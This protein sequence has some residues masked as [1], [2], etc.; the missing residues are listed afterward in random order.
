M[1]VT[2]PKQISLEVGKTKWSE[3]GVEHTV[4]KIIDHPG[5]NIRI[6]DD[7]SL[8]EVDRAFQFNRK[9]QPV[10]IYPHLYVPVGSRVTVMGWGKTDPKSKLYEVRRKAKKD[11]APQRFENPKNTRSLAAIKYHMVTG[12]KRACKM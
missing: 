4:R 8:L 12:G 11:F 7:I 5:F 6:N 9:V 10:A 3:K 2:S 1:G